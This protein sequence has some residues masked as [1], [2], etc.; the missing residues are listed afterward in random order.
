MYMIILFTNYLRLRE[1][2]LWE[3]KIKQKCRGLF[4]IWYCNSSRGVLEAVRALRLV[5]SPLLAFHSIQPSQSI[6]IP[7]PINPSLHLVLSIW[8]I[9]IR[10]GEA[11]R[12]GDRRWRTRRMTSRRGYHSRRSRTTAGCWAAS[13][14]TSSSAS[15]APASSTS[16]SASP[17]SPR[18]RIHPYMMMMMMVIRSN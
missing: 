10:S 7:I 4:V 6:S 15:S 14:T 8:G 13:S 3:M 17:S 16:S 1:K 9:R 11:R 2:T 12:G 5:S 18:Y